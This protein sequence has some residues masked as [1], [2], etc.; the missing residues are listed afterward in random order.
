MPGGPAWKLQFPT[1]LQFRKHRNCRIQWLLF[2]VR[3]KEKSQSFEK[4]RQLKTERVNTAKRS[5]EQVPT[6]LL[7]AL[8]LEGVALWLGPMAAGTKRGPNSEGERRFITHGSR[9]ILWPGTGQKAG[10]WGF[11]FACYLGGAATWGVLL[12]RAPRFTRTF[13]F[14][15]SCQGASELHFFRRWTLFDG[16]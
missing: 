15:V 1:H 16:F 10:R 5:G 7:L 13:T 3:S 12:R 6:D 11:A 4:V 14:P 9:Q 8:S 2:G